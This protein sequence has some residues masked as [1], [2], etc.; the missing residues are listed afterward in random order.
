MAVRYCLTGVAWLAGWL[1]VL[2]L[3]QLEGVVRPRPLLLGAAAALL[4][5]LSLLLSPFHC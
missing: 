3:P 1:G 2:Q 4:L 5:L